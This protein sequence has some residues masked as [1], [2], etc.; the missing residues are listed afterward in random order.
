MLAP[1]VSVDIII[2][3]P[4]QRAL[5]G[6]RLNEP[7]KGYY[8]VPGGVIRKFETIQ[9]AFSRILEAETGLNASIN[10]A[11]FMGVF[12]HFYETN[13]FEGPHLWDPLRRPGA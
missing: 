3:D 11:K 8:F 5:I 7:A 12:E 13:R 6:L 4:E 10:Q 2:K 1:L 9:S